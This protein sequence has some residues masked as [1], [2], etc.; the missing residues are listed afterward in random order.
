M[1]ED[2]YAALMAFFKLHPEYKRP[3]EGLLGS[4]TVQK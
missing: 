1:R 2:F 3:E 4:K